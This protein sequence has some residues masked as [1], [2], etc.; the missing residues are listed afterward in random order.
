MRHTLETLV[1]AML[2]CDDA[3]MGRIS[4]ISFV[5]PLLIVVA[6]ECQQVVF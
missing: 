5:P 4:K 1:E 6:E 2:A 3:I